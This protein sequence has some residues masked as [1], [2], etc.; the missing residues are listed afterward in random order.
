MHLYALA[1]LPMILLSFSYPM[2]SGNDEFLNDLKKMADGFANAK[3]YVI[4]A[5][6]QV[7]ENEGKKKSLSYTGTVMMNEDSY[8]MNFNG[9]ISLANKKCML[10]ITDAQKTIYYN[11]PLNVAE[12]K[13]KLMKDGA[14]QKMLPDSSILR[15]ATVKLLSETAGEKTYQLAYKDTASPYSNIDL[16]FSLPGYKLKSFNY[17]YKKSHNFSY[18]DV[19]IDYTTFKI[20]EPVPPGYF[21]E[22]QFISS[23][24]T[25]KGVGKYASYK[26]TDYRNTKHY[27]Q[28]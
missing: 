14:G 20:N 17:S 4:T 11:K 2:Y 15:G 19:K 3:S 18:S 6:V 25:L 10:L 23:S 12:I 8:Y 21:D 24:H 5:Q 1:L 28:K 27:D 7:S 22:K 26:I 9:M 16:T 13:K